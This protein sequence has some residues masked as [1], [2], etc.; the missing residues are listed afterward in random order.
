MQGSKRKSSVDSEA[1][2]ATPPPRKQPR[3]DSDL[4]SSESSATTKQ[5][6][7]LVDKEATSDSTNDSAVE[8]EVVKP[9]VTEGDE[10]SQAMTESECLY[11]EEL[12]EGSHDIEGP[13][14][15]L[16]TP[17][18]QLMPPGEMDVV[19]GDGG[20]AD[21]EGEEVG[22]KPE[23]D[24][25]NVDGEGRG[26]KPESDSLDDTRMEVE[27]KS[28]TPPTE[29]PPTESPPKSP[30][31]FPPPRSLPTNLSVSHD[32]T[33]CSQSIAS[34][35]TSTSTV[36][37]GAKK[38]DGDK[39]NGGM[40]H[41]SASGR[42][43]L[44][45]AIHDHTYCSQREEGEDSIGRKTTPVPGDKED[46]VKG[47]KQAVLPVT[48]HDHTYAS[49]FSEQRNEPSSLVEPIPEHQ[50]EGHSNGSGALIEEETER[51]EEGEPRKSSTAEDD[52]GMENGMRDMS[53]QVDLD[54]S[55]DSDVF[56]SGEPESSQS[57]ELFSQQASQ[58]NGQVQGYQAAGNRTRNEAASGEPLPTVP[59]GCHSNSE[60][61][62]IG[63]AVEG[64]VVA[65]G[66]GGVDQTPGSKSADSANRANGNEGKEESS[67]SHDTVDRGC[68]QKADDVMEVVEEET[69]IATS[70]TEISQVKVAIQ[71]HS[72]STG[73]DGS[74]C[75]S[76][77]SNPTH[78]AECSQRPPSTSSDV[79][80]SSS[81]SSLPV[82]DSTHLSSPSTVSSEPNK[83]LDSLSRLKEVREEVNKLLE[84][85]SSLTRDEMLACHEAVGASM[86]FTQKIYHSLFQHLT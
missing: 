57:Q 79:A 72:V 66:D 38:I 6:S 2:L 52:V 60:D 55:V 35:E 64:V 58:V 33:Y 16:C 12:S 71:S 7:T 61:Q 14:M 51:G 36:L 82:T 48:N 77:S 21:V 59:H 28:Q 49:S 26:N 70:A 46:V 13:M 27:E 23:S 18:S 54:T 74:G 83:L 86:V 20:P 62:G 81:S 31:T 69:S 30:P 84:E 63:E 68:G 73:S 32:H 47:E 8:P 76:D 50:Q 39:V 19:D 53:T 5:P 34:E 3:L 11:D 44:S 4:L 25:G 42:S 40:S 45:M 41:V 67:E 75:S 22:K 17:E 78:I 37:N 85:N 29:S 43:M 24:S 80:P 10:T 56:M 15:T 1:S 9:A 65:R